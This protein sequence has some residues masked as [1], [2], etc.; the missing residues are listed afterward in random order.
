LNANRC[1][2]VTLSGAPKTLRTAGENNSDC[3]SPKRFRRCRDLAGWIASGTT[4]A[5]LPK[6]P[7]CLAAYVAIG[8]GVE[9]SVPTAAFIQLI[10]VILCLG[11]LCYLAF[12]FMRRAMART[13]G[14]FSSERPRQSRLPGPAFALR[15]LLLTI[16][17]S[18]VR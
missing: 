13:A 10:L 15:V 9:L 17:G 4:L 12:L 16:D 1:C 18:R 14:L 2:T 6:C 7:A 3:L 8:T 5:L 11:S